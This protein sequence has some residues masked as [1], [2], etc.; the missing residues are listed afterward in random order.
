MPAVIL[1]GLDHRAHLEHRVAQGHQAV[2]AVPVGEELGLDDPGGVGQC[3]CTAR[4]GN[5]DDI[6]GTVV[7]LMSD[8]GAWVNGQTWH[9]NGGVYYGD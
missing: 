3:D 9:V 5:P 7:Y 6:A 2:L 8:D 4:H 1:E